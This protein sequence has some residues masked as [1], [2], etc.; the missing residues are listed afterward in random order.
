MISSDAATTHGSLNS[1]PLETIKGLTPPAMGQTSSAVENETLTTDAT[2]FPNVP[3][4]IT[5]SAGYFMT[6]WLDALNIVLN[7][8]KPSVAWAWDTCQVLSGSGSVA[9]GC[10]Q[11]TGW[12]QI[13]FNWQNGWGSSSAYS[14]AS[15]NYY[16]AVFCLLLGQN[17]GTG[18]QYLYS[19]LYGYPDGSL[20]GEWSS[21]TYGGCT[22]II[23][24]NNYVVRTLH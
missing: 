17:K 4:P 1:R 16:D 22:G 24:S 18:V 7:F 6:E 20:S 8:I 13:A 21:L 3:P 10:S 19:N 11:A 12:T 2:I 15:G 14:E 5:H 23:H 9:Q